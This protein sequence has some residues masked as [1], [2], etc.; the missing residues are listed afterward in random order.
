[1]Q[2]AVGLADAGL[3]EAAAPLALAAAQITG[4]DALLAAARSLEG[5]PRDA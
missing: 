3:L 5:V 2:V 4:D 1:M